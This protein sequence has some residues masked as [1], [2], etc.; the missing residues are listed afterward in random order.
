MK[1]RIL[2]ASLLAGGVALI[3]G[4]AGAK[5]T[6]SATI[7]GP[8]L[9]PPIE[10]SLDTSMQPGRTRGPNLPGPN[11]LANAA[12][13]FAVW[14]SSA[15]KLSA[16]PPSG[17]LGPRYVI[18][19]H[20]LVGPNTTKPIHQDLYPLATA[21]PLT[22]APLGQRVFAGQKLQGGWYRADQ[23]LTNLLILIGIPAARAT[24]ARTQT[25]RPMPPNPSSQA[26]RQQPLRVGEQR[27]G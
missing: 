16:S 8:G 22:Y 15:A 20:W 25:P 4:V 9:H 3:P 10:L 7:V 2:A 27:S 17:P 6:R 13:L 5:G 12:G 11:D 21:G 19:Y 14:A 18:T 24:Q 23:R 1:R 26:D